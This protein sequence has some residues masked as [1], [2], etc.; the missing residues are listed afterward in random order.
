MS[1]ILKKM[2]LIPAKPLN[3]NI[4]VKRVIG[5]PTKEQLT[6]LNKAPEK[7]KKGRDLPKEPVFIEFYTEIYDLGDAVDCP[8]KVGDLVNIVVYGTETVT[9]ED[10]NDLQDI[11]YAIINPNQV[12]GIYQ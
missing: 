6:E 5:K 1:N 9:A 11:S 10:G 7:D 8:F 4:I 2:P 12:I 3:G